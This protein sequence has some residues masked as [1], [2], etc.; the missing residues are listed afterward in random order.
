M[1]VVHG[2]KVLMKEDFTPPSVDV[3]VFTLAPVVVYL[4][5]FMTIM[6][7]PF[8]PDLTS[9]G[10]EFG[11]LYFFAIGGLGVVG[12]MMA[13][14]SSFNKYSLLGGIRAA[15]QAISY[16]IPYRNHRRSEPN[17]VRQH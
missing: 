6:V 8:A 16:E 12:L 15:A 3:P 2:L 7:I 9:V 1:S 5:S 14:W 4:A 13:G 17:T 11:L 10:L